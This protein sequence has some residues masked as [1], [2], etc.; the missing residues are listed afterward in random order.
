MNGRIYSIS[1]EHTA[2]GWLCI[3]NGFSRG[4]HHD[5]ELEAL[6]CAD[7]WRT[8]SLARMA[9]DRARKP[10]LYVNAS[11]DNYPDGRTGSTFVQQLEDEAMLRAGE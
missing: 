8:V 1:A 5:S 7:E 10:V 2:G 3:F 9:S 11:D 4:H 6:R